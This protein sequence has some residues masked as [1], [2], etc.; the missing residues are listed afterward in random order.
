M[1]HQL[2]VQKA[3]KPESWLYLRFF[4]EA[5]GLEQ[6]VNMSFSFDDSSIRFHQDIQSHPEQPLQQCFPFCRKSR[7]ALLPTDCRHSLHLWFFLRAQ[8]EWEHALPVSSPMQRMSLVADLSGNVDEQLWKPPPPLYCI[9]ARRLQ[10][11]H[12]FRPTPIF[13][14]K[15]HGVDE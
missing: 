15:G 9:N 10:R 3:H 6:L 2:D 4:R 8:I 7:N 13:A 11:L 12:L 1:L 5:I 14:S